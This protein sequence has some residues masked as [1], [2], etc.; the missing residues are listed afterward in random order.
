MIP[1]GCGLLGKDNKGFK[2]ENPKDS[3]LSRAV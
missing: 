1:C 3:L 2:S